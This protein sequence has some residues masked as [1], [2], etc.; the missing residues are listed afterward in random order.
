M[1]FSAY[2]HVGNDDIVNNMIHTICK[3]G[4]VKHHSMNVSCIYRNDKIQEHSESL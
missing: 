1:R 4:S 2:A 3:V